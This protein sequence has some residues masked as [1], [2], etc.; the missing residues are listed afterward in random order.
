V[1]EIIVKV[2]MSGVMWQDITYCPKSPI[3]LK[4]KTNHFASSEN[5]IIVYGMISSRDLINGSK[6]M[7]HSLLDNNNNNNNNNN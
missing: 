4:S 6:Y 7:G 1:A 3:C 2:V 5:C